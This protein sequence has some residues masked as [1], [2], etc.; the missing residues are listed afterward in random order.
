MILFVKLVCLVRGK[1]LKALGIL[2]L[3]CLTVSCFDRHG[4][5]GAIFRLRDDST[6]PQW[7]VL[8]S[9]M[10][11][12][13]V[14]IEIVRYEATFTP[15]CKV[16]FVISDKQSHVL[17]EKLG[18]MWWHPD[19]EREDRPAGTLPSWSIIEVDGIKEVY[20]KSERNE[21]LR[22]VEKPLN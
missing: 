19:S 20:E 6:L 8:P 10:S 17:Q 22:I 2:I 16:R 3:L 9:G 11:R 13:Q 1:L 7:F 5:I 12:G 15:K 14:N 21:L 4:V 18:Y